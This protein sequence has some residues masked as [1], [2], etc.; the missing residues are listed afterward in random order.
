MARWDRRALHYGWVVVAITFAMGAIAAGVRAAPQ[1]YINPLEAEFGWNRAAT[2]AAVSISLLLFGFGAPLSGKLIDRFGPRRVMLGSLT[3]M[4]LGVAGTIGL[5]ELWQLHLLWGVFVGLGA[6]GGGSVLFASVAARWFLA[7]RGMIVGVLGSTTAT[8][9]FIFLP[10]LMVVIVSYGWRAASIALVGII[11]AVLVPVLF[12]MR[13]DPASVGLKS[14]GAEHVSAAAAARSDGPAVA[15][16]Q[17]ARTREFWLLA[18][19]YF[20][21]GATAGGLIGTHMI[22][23][24]IDH[25][26]PEVTAAATVGVM[27]VMN[28]VGTMLSGWLTDRMNP[29]K[30]LAMVYALRGLALFVFPFV[31]DFLGLFVF[32]LVYGLDLS[33]TVPPTV[34]L[35]VSRFGKRSIGGIYGW[36]F[37]SHQFGAAVAAMAAGTV[38]VVM[39]DYMV[40]FLAGGVVALMGAS[41]ALFIRSTQVEPAAAPASPVAV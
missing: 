25:G 39:G 11:L 21:C 17:A 36:I 16:I 32:A 4:A 8:G 37:A 12:W 7:R 33:A 40:A 35:T 27:G 15:V 24:S 10:L 38:R 18:G 26:I 6:A 2:S 13:D 41:M 34:A 1:V 28:F 29:R 31:N 9:Q 20:V 14:Y 22:P 19:S 3:L 5:T 23:H 30:L